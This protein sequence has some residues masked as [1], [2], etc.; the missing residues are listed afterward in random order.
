MDR[1]KRARRISRKKIE[2]RFPDVTIDLQ[3]KFASIKL[4][5]GVEARSYQKRGFVFCEDRRG[6]IIEIQVLNLPRRTKIKAA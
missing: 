4:H 5:P 3:N 6:R 2:K 1:P